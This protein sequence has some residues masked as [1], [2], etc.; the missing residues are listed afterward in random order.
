[1]QIS[2]QQ[3][4]EITVHERGAERALDEVE[5]IIAEIQERITP[6]ALAGK[7]GNAG[8]EATVGRVGRAIDDI[9]DKVSETGGALVERVRENAIASVLAGAGVACLVMG[10]A[11]S[12]GPRR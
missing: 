12:G 10:R 6:Q 9:S 1:M 7:A 3:A 11:R 2:E 4:Q 8:K 5:A